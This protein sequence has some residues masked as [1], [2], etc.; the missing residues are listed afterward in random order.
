M[1]ILLTGASGNFGQTYLRQ[2]GHDVVPLNRH[3]WSEL[4]DRLSGCDAIIHAA[5]DLHTKVSDTPT[6]SLDTNIMSTSRLLEAARHHKVDRFVFISS[7]AVYGESMRT[8]ETTTCQPNSIN[9]VG[10]RLNE[11]VIAEFCQQNDIAHQILRVFN[12]YGGQDNFS[13]LSHIRR[14]LNNDQP[15]T[16]NNNGIAQR[17]FIHVN[18]VVAIVAQLMGQPV[19]HQYLNIG[20][21]VSTR[22]SEIID[23]VRARFPQLQITSSKTQ[24]AEYSRADI[25]RLLSI[26]EP[27]FTDITAYLQ[28]DFMEA[29]S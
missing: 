27:E 6:L 13:I 3:D 29:S 26:L 9:G 2:S 4:N 19:T 28:N 24:E 15:F 14:A 17:D 18:D 20:T 11:M 21:G 8:G 12:M 16:L 5:S 10:K 1:K 25:G 7:C 22:I 23:I